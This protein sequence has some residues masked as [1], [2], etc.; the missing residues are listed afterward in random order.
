MGKKRQYYGAGEGSISKRTD[1]VFLLRYQDTEKEEIRN[2]GPFSDE[3][4][5]FERLNSFL[6]K[7][8]CSWLVAYN[9]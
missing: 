6:K 7:G 9:E 2:E 5:A 1:R 3:E 4:S 8:I